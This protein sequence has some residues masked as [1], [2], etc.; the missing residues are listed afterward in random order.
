MSVFIVIFHW[1]QAKIENFLSILLG[2]NIIFT[3]SKEYPENFFAHF[4]LARVR[5]G[6]T[7]SLAVVQWGYVGAVFVK[8]QESMG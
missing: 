7:C 8:R 1:K 5:Q 3:L 6:S 2:F 4:I